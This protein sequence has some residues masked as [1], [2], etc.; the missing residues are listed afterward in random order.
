[1][2]TSNIKEHYLTLQQAVFEY[3]VCASG[4]LLF[5]MVVGCGKNCSVLCFH[6]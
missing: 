4:L 1:M 2:K 6:E 5:Q 3:C